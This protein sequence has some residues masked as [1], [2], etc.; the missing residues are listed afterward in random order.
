MPTLKVLSPENFSRRAPTDLTLRQ[1]T[2]RG[3]QDGQGSRVLPGVRGR[4]EP[5]SYECVVT[6][7]I[8]TPVRRRR[9]PVDECKSEEAGSGGRKSGA[10]IRAMNSGNAEGA[11]GRRFEITP[12]GYTALRREDFVCDHPTR[13]FHTEGA[14]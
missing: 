8:R 14:Q 13:A 4:I 2:T 6:E 11:K 10:S 7:E 3:P 9:A 1:A 12:E 5:D